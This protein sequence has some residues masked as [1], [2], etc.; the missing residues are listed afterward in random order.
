MN[1]VTIFNL[2]LQNSQENEEQLGEM[3]R[4]CEK[5]CAERSELHEELSEMVGT[6]EE[7][8]T[9]T[10]RKCRDIVTPQD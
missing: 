7:T 9:S 2:Q 3:V 8:S 5:M 1:N 10:G 4:A 6:R